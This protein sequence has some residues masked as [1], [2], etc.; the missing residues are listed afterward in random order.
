MHNKYFGLEK[1]WK[2]PD[3]VICTADPN[4]ALIEARSLDG[5]IKSIFVPHTQPTPRLLLGHPVI[6]VLNVLYMYMYIN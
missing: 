1:D 2:L 3:P 5:A 4:L 6:H